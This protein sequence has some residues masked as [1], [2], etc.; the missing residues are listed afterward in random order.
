MA[1]STVRLGT[2]K[3]NLFSISPANTG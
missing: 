3:L 2:S 1:E